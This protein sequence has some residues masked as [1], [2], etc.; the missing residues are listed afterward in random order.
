MRSLIFNAHVY[1][2]LKSLFLLLSVIATSLSERF[3]PKTLQFKCI[4]KTR[5]KG[6]KHIESKH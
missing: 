3:D 2:S 4:K 1:E 5:R 6:K